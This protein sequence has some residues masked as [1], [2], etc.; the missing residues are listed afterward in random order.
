MCVTVTK[1]GILWSGML[2]SFYIIMVIIDQIDG[3]IINLY[4]FILLKVEINAKS[5]TIS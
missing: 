2:A 1:K 4:I 5:D 3:F